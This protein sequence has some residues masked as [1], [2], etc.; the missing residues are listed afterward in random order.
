MP[1]TMV[2]ILAKALLE[3]DIELGAAHFPNLPV[4]RIRHEAETELRGDYRELAITALQALREP[5]EAMGF[6]LRRLPRVYRPGSHSAL[7]IYRAMID[8]ALNEG[9]ER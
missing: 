2:E 1:E 4:D 9:A 3:R 7:E 5:T 6:G 8:A